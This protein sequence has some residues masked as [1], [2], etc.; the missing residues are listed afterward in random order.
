MS[1]PWYAPG[2]GDPIGTSFSA[3]LGAVLRKHRVEMRLSLRDLGALT[4]HQRTHLGKIESGVSNP[5]LDL[6]HE[7]ARA[8][9]CTLGQLMSEAESLSNA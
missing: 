8:L 5:S 6:A 7:L 3:R 2:A 1:A 9:G 4:G